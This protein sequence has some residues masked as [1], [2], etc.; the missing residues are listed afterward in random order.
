MINKICNNILVT[1]GEGY[2][3]QIYANTKK[4]K[5]ILIWRPKYNNI[6]L[7]IQSTIQ[8]GKN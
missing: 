7:N 8:W 4:F 1:G 5:K 6:R 3:S 2:I